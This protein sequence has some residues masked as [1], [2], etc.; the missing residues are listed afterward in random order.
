[1]RVGVGT[2]T[3]PEEMV[4]D[5]RGEEAGSWGETEQNNGAKR[6]LNFR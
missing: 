4:I 3:W 5:V 1:M 6:Q 2:G